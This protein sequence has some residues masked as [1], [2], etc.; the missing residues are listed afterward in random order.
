MNDPAIFLNFLDN[1]LQVRPVRVREE[2][3]TFVET[4]ENILSSSDDEIDDFVKEIHA[5]NSART[6]NAK[7]LIG[8]NVV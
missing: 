6:S 2:I 3:I 5:S 8:S 1:I 4:F 7:L